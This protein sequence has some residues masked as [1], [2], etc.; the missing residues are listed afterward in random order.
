MVAMPSAGNVTFPSRYLIAISHGTTADRK[1][2]FSGSFRHARPPVEKRSPWDRIQSQT[3]VSRR[4]RRRG[5]LTFEQGQEIVR[6]RCDEVVV[7]ND[8]APVDIQ[9]IGHPARTVSGDEP[10]DGLTGPGNHDFLPAR[11]FRQEP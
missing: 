4:I 5:L 1:N 2:V 6:E 8:A 10:G 7:D 11:N 3:C 9:E